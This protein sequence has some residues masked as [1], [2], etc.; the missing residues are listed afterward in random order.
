MSF[1]S[2]LPRTRPF[3]LPSVLVYDNRARED[4]HHNQFQPRTSQWAYVYATVR[5]MDFMAAL[6]P[7]PDV[8]P[9][10]VIEDAD[11]YPCVVRLHKYFQPCG[12][13][14]N[15]TL[16]I[17]L[18]HAQLEKSSPGHRLRMS[19]LFSLTVVL[20]S[21]LDLDYVIRSRFLNPEGGH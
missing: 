17:A 10:T 3:E 5:P 21:V 14:K 19:A 15:G 20:R 12:G 8:C 13:R 1:T 11:E 7:V 16:E 18:P 9:D 4:I 6:H 2:Q